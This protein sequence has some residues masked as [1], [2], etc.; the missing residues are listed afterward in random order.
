MTITD[1]QVAALHAQLAGRFDEYRR[2][3]SDMTKEEANVGFAALVAAG[4]FEAIRRR[5]IRDG[6]P[7][8]DAEVIEFV[9]DS[10]GRTTNAAKIIVPDIAELIINLSLGKL[11]IDAKEGID[12]NVSFKIKT[13]LLA[14][15]IA[16]EDFSEVE[17]EDFLVNVRELAE[18]SLR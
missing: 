5:F 9:A 16:D 18:E 6:E 11:P 1:N 14:L 3:L 15:L 13:L 8:S 10:R 4:F 2:L 12:D 17:L 7:A